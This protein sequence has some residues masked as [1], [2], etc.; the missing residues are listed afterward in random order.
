MFKVIALLYARPDVGRIA[1]IE[2]Y[3]NHHV[4]LI[5]GRA[6]APSSYKRNYAADDA[7][8]DHSLPDIVTELVFSD[9]AAYESWVAVMYSPD[10]GIAD[11]EQTIL[12]RSRT[13]SMAVDEYISD[14]TML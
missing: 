5:L 9:R 13:T 14:T 8:R 6:P 11:D 1:V 4:P 10:S 7:W 12:D 3:E 2:H